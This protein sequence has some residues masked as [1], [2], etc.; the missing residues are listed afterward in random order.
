VP[1][2]APSNRPEP[3]TFDALFP[4]LPD[5]ESRGQVWQYVNGELKPLRV[6]LGITDG[7][8][9]ELLEGDIEEGTELVTNV[10]TGAET[11][12]T[13]TGGGAFSPFM[14]PQRFGG[15]GGG[16]NNRGG[17]NQGRGR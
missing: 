13:P 3:T 15:G 6:R 8:A 11:R 4:P 10:L 14:G 9:S 17:G 16:N 5:V 12:P 1:A 7:Q 2:A